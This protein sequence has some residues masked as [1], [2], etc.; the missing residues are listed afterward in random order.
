LAAKLWIDET[1]ET[2]ASGMSGSPVLDAGGAAIGVVSRSS[3][4]RNLGLHHQGMSP[5]LIAHLPGWLVVS[6]GASK[7]FADET[8]RTRAYY[9]R[10]SEEM[11]A[12]RKLTSARLVEA[13]RL[14]T[15]RNI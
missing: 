7:A 1:S 12:R 15:A 3:G 5:R 2:I 8:K 9:R 10:Q 13:V 4:D 6:L 11:K 14:K